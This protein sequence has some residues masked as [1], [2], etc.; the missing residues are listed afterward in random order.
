[1][2]EIRYYEWLKKGKERIPYFTKRED[3]RL[4]LLAGMYDVAHLDGLSSSQIVFARLAQPSILM[5]MS[6]QTAPLWTFTIIT[7]DANEKFSWLHDRQPVILST[8]EALQAWLDTS[9]QQWTPQLTQLVQPY[10][11]D[12]TLSW[13][14]LA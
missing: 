10:S 11:G 13:Y 3:G 1:M 12:A 6:G 2:N 8:T 7:T 14:A 4:M 9:S 5:L